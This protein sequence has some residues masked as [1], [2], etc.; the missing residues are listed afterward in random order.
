[1]MMN[2]AYVSYD[3]EFL[4]TQ[5]HIIKSASVA[6]KVVDLLNLEKTYDTFMDQHEKG[7]S[8]A[9][10]LTGWIS[11][12]VSVLKN[13]F[14]TTTEAS[15]AS[16]PSDILEEKRNAIIDMISSCIVVSPIPESRLVTINFTSPNPV[17]WRP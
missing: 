8:I 11:S 3:P 10:S 2:Y 15:V 17:N 16:D 5:S 14:G 1:M 12:L 6:E 7:F 9:Q 4:T 13:V